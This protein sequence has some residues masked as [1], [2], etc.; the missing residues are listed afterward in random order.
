[1]ALEALADLSFKKLS[2]EKETKN[3]QQAQSYK[4]QAINYLNQ[5]LETVKINF[6]EDSPHIAE[7]SLKLEKIKKWEE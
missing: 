5:A 1:M 6:P 3:I 2:H 4:N 7:I